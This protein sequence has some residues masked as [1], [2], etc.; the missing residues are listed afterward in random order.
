M[1]ITEAL[2]SFSSRVTDLRILICYLSR[3]HHAD[4]S[5]QKPGNVL[6]SVITHT[7]NE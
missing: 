4:C 2:I 1:V 5:Q 6:H 3:F 7:L